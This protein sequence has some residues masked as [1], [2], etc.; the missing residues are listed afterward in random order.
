MP[1]SPHAR[2]I[3][4]VPRLDGC[5]L[6]VRNLDDLRPGKESAG[7]MIVML[8]GQAR[9]VPMFTRSVH[10]G[11]RAVRR[12]HGFASKVNGWSANDEFMAT[13]NWPCRMPW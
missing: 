1:Q 13:L 6:A 8:E 2:C 3:P 12:Y 4:I 5:R 11:E 7:A 9:A 10:S